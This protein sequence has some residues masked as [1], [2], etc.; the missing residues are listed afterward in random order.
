PRVGGVGGP[1]VRESGIALD[2]PA[3]REAVADFGLEV[4]LVDAA[5]VTIPGERGE[6]VGQDTVE[7][8]TA[9]VDQGP[10]R[11]GRPSPGSQP[12]GGG[13]RELYDRSEAPYPLRRLGR[14]QEQ[15][16][17]QVLEPEL[18]PGGGQVGGGDRGAEDQIPLRAQRER[19]HR[20]DVDALARTVTG[21]DPEAG[22]ELD[23]QLY[24]L[25]E[26][27][28]RVLGQL[29]RR[30]RRGLLCACR[31]RKSTRLNSS[32]QIISYAVFCLKKKSR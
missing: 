7:P 30:R 23:R 9:R 27:I 25:G 26:G 5:A 4:G 24:E 10:G 31:D 32:H 14:R 29:L 19:Q 1:V 12:I 2:V 8:R 3:A 20:L 13:R 15:R 11:P 6:V 16:R 28:A 21:P 18:R 22:R 17:L